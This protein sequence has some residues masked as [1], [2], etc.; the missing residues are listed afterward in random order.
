[1]KTMRNIWTT[2]AT[3]FKVQSKAR[4]MNLH[5]E[6]M[7][8]EQVSKYHPEELDTIPPYLSIEE[9]NYLKAPVLLRVECSFNQINEVF[10][11]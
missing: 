9:S 1:M 3:G 5:G 2:R 10:G 7:N 6:V 11:L 4:S 8:L